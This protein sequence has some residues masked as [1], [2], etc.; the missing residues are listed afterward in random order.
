PDV[1]ADIS[2]DDL[3]L[4]AGGHVTGPNDVRATIEPV[5]HAPLQVPA[6]DGRVSRLARALCRLE[7]DDGRRGW[8]WA[9]RLQPA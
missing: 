2:L 5:R 7:A 1:A 8:A 3:G 9:E 4:V 6:A